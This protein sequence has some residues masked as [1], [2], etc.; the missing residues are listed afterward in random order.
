MGGRCIRGQSL[1]QIFLI[2]KSG[3]TLVEL[4]AALAISTI[5]LGIAASVLINS[6][7]SYNNITSEQ[8][9]EQEANLFITQLR[10]IHQQHQSY[11]I[12]YDKNENVYIVTYPN[13]MVD[14]LG[15]RNYQFEIDINNEIISES[16]LFTVTPDINQLH[17]KMTVTKQNSSKS[18]EI[19]T[20]IIRV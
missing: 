6:M 12:S 7:N 8:L 10:T 3:L 9:L 13:G 4:L 5:I 2:N 20:G 17:L 19:K 18:F 14:T 15:N 11:T 16:Q 1:K